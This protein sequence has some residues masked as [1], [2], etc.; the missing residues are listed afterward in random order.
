MLGQRF[1]QFLSLIFLCCLLSSHSL[2]EDSDS[3]ESIGFTQTV[4][5][6]LGEFTVTVSTQ[7]NVILPVN[8]LHNWV[9]EVTDKA[10]KAVYPATFRVSGGMPSHGHGLPTQP[11]ITTHLGDGRYLLE[12]VKFNMYGA[13]QMTFIIS[14]ESVEDKAVVDFDINF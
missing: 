12:G 5:S 2:A 10:D 1:S 7:K 6:T 11:I 9:V 8:E 14:T 4:L 3:A 13:W